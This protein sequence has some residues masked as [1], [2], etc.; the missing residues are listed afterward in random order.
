MN[1]QFPYTHT[2]ESYDICCNDDDDKHNIIATYP[3]LC[4]PVTII[5][6]IVCFIPMLC[7]YYTIIPVQN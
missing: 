1:C 4:L 3:L 6:D 5:A 2:K 7:G